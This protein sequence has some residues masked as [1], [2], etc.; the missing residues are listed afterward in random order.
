LQQKKSEKPWFMQPDY[1][2]DELVFG[3]ERQVK[4]GTLAA[5]VEQLTFHEYAD[6]RYIQCFLWTFRSFSTTQQV[7]E[8]LEKRYNLPQPPSLTADE[9]KQW[10]EAKLHPVRLRVINVL[11]QWIETY[12]DDE[13]E[14]LVLPRVK[15]FY[16]SH[17]N[18]QDRF[19]QQLINLVEKRV[20]IDWTLQDWKEDDGSA[21]FGVSF[22]FFSSSM[23]MNYSAPKRRSGR[24][25]R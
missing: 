1:K 11:K 7:L 14:H 18:S 3:M 12:L 22:F 8:L 9:L 24:M 20:S 21:D 23:H 2:K 15:S 10:T 25:G 6:S 13:D 17:S 19:V 16:T 4:G 5:L